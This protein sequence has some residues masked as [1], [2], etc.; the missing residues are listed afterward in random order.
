M[1]DELAKAILKLAEVHDRRGGEIA[2]GLDRVATQIKFLGNG[3]AVDGGMGAIENLANK[4]EEGT[5]SIAS[6]L[7]EVANEMSRRKN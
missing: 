7:N 1:S 2:E 4:I 6:C 5:D 3:N